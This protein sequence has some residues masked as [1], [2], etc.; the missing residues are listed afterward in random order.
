MFQIVHLRYTLSFIPI[1]EES[2]TPKVKNSS[3][4]YNSLIIGM[5][6]T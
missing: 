1:C 4:F 3:F 6:L 2:Y 5:V